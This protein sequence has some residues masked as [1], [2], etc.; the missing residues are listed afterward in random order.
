M[1]IV[2]VADELPASTVTLE[3][4]VAAE[5]DV[6][7]L[8]GV[9]TV[10]ALLMVRGPIPVLLP[11]MVAGLTTTLDIVGGRTVIDRLI[12][13]PFAVALMITFLFMLTGSVVIVKFAVALPAKTV[14]LVGTNALGSA[15]ARVTMISPGAAGASRVMI[16][17]ALVPPR[18]LVGLNERESGLIGRTA[19]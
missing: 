1:E 7:R 2:K 16:P 15:L 11:M 3:G 18:T 4:R 6:L 19:R 10:T 9:S 8:I 12:V 13:R 14:I 5:F 17:D